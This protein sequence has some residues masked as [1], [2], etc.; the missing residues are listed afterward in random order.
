MAQQ[1]LSP[2]G[3]DHIGL[4]MFLN[5]EGG[6]FG[7]SGGDE[8]FV[9]QMTAFRDRGQGAVV[10]TNSDRPATLI[11]ELLRGIAVAYEWPNYLPKARV[12]VAVDT[13]AAA[14]AGAYELRPGYRLVVTWDQGGLFLAPPGQPPDA[15]AIARPLRPGFG[16]L[17]GGA[18]A[19]GCV[20]G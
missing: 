15:A 11:Q 8:G 10:T 2:Q 6:W 17:L 9:C 14:S 12:P 1:M 20:R 5:K 18:A 19:G 7:H 16:P 4:G 3:E 13:P